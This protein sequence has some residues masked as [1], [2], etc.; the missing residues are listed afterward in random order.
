MKIS[1]VIPVR[2]EED[3]IRTLL[4]CVLGQTR[5]PDEVVVT[6]GG[7]TD[8]TPS[9]IEEYVRRG[10]PVRL[11]RE[12]AA[13][14]G[15][16]RNVA[17]A[18]ASF[19]WLAFADAARGPRGWLEALAERVERDPTVEVVYGNWESITDNFSRSAPRCL[20]PRHAHRSEGDHPAAVV[21]RR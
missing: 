2:N 7:S 9:I 6:D 3:S 19:D 13:L 15:R 18:G 20:R 21:A 11:I 16:G 5:K 17:A 8:M 12:A 14:P 4:D 10:A 1:V